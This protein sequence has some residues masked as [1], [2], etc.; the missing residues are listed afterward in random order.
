MQKDATFPS[1]RTTSTLKH[2][3][4]Q[5]CE[6]L[7]IP[8]STVA[9]TLLRLWISGKINLNLELDPDFVKSAQEALDAEESQQAIAKLAHHYDPQRKYANAIKLS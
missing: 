3:V 6:S 5:A 7:N 1:I 4:Y 9:E 8:F 2:Q